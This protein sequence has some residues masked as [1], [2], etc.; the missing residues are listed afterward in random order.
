MTG[1]PPP[2]SL[3]WAGCIGYAENLL[4]GTTWPYVQVGAYDAWI[5]DPRLPHYA[6]EYVHLDPNNL[7]PLVP[8]ASAVRLGD[9]AYKWLLEIRHN[10]NP[11]TPGYGSAIFFHVRRGPDVPTGQ[12]APPWPST[13]LKSW[14]AG[15]AWTSIPAYYV[16]LPSSE[17]DKN[18]E[19]W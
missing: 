8:I 6:N 19:K 9:N 5:D 14:F 4:R 16:L 2:A 12:A 3:N 13:I 18:R 11:A 1:A 10:V 17:Y 7:A 15:C